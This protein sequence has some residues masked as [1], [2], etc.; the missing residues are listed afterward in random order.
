MIILHVRIRNFRSIATL[1][2]SVRDRFV[3]LVGPGDSGKTTV[4]E[5][6]D[7]ALGRQWFTATDADFRNTI[8]TPPI[9]IEVSVGELPTGFLD[10]HGPGTCLHGWKDGVLHDEPEDD[11]EIVVTV[12]LVIDD[13][14][15]PIWTLTG[16]AGAE[17]VPFRAKDRSKLKLHRL[18]GVI[19]HQLG[20]GRGSLLSRHSGAQG[21]I[22]DV[23]SSAARAIRQST[24]TTG[25]AGIQETVDRA[26]RV[27]DQVGVEVGDL[28]AAINAADLTLGG[29]LL[30]L[31]DGNIPVRQMGLGSRRLLAVGLELDAIEHGGIGLI[32]EIEHGL[33]PYRIHTLLEQVKRIT[34]ATAGQAFVTT[35]SAVVIQ[36]C[37]AV[38][39]YVV[40]T[41]DGRTTI[42][43]VP[44]D[45][46]MQALLR[47]SS[48]AV[49]ARKVIV[50]EGKTEYGMCRGLDAA[51]TSGDRKSFAA[52]GCVPVDG[53]GSSKAASAAMNLRMLGYTVC[54]FGDS[55]EPCTPS[56]AEMEAA[57]VEVIRW[58]GKWAVE[59]A[60]FRCL[61]WPEV[62]TILT[63]I[64]TDKV[65]ANPSSYFKGEASRLGRQ[66]IH[67][68]DQP[69]ESWTYS[70]ALLDALID[71]SRGKGTKKD[72]SR[73]WLK[74]IDIGSYIGQ[75]TVTA[76]PTLPAGNELRDRILHLRAW[77]DG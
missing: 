32:D 11:D 13:S 69:C 44:I 38:P 25:I 58:Q 27:A 48:D 59:D 46:G 67:D 60:V 55:D 14:L 40:R 24:T 7:L 4:F 3:V 34:T 76:L 21:E 8:T 64:G 16:S 2:W 26:K 31:H 36:T 1:D 77:I 57:G 61:P 50:C 37:G 9:E 68:W 66:N 47:G 72:G 20:W 6:I 29:G 35:H 71:M 5:A 53:A 62:T 73:L 56:W 30:S 39:T 23:M 74:T 12:R 52:N 65:A 15:E 43:K 45:N 10:L 70:T 17:G 42:T 49:F 51:W 63:A 41:V 22:N 18:G 19:D 28:K 54:F 33:E 75:K